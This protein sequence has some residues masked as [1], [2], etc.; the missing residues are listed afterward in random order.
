M[1]SI[2]R[3]HVVLGG[4]GEPPGISLSE[5]YHEQTKLHPAL[6]PPDLPVTDPS[7]AERRA[8]LRGYKRYPR[9]PQVPLPLVPPPV[10]GGPLFDAVLA[11]RR[12]AR[13]FGAS[14]LP[15]AA[16]GRVLQQSYGIS[17]DVALSDG[18]H[19]RS[20]AV[21][22]AGA[23]YPAEIYLGVRNVG[24]L[25]PGIYHYEVNEH[26]LA[27]LDAGDPAERLYAACLQQPY[28][29]QAAVVVLVAGVV[30]RTKRK[31]GERGY[32]FVLLEIGHLAQNLHL[33]S[34]AL[35]LSFV[36]IGGYYDDLLNDM[37]R[38][39]GIDETIMYVAFLGNA[40]GPGP[41][42]AGDDRP[43]PSNGPPEEVR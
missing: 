43:R 16:L 9:H 32:R 8:M 39:H 28:A 1:S 42:A 6:L 31:Y 7:R 21:P 4:R 37:L 24:G 23:L 30:E 41:V 11:R 19:L 27:L 26:A 17:G 5:L 20:R 40:A 14:P 2:L 33:A 22:S 10:E 12:S 34:T 3:R 18:L 36:A 15:L 13:A 25:R 38:L 29:R 35:D